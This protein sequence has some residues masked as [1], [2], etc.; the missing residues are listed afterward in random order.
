M[1]SLLLFIGVP[2]ANKNKDFTS[3]LRIDNISSI[4]MFNVVG[5]VYEKEIN[6]EKYI[7]IEE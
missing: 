3:I 7:D 6:S 2:N 1:L 4:I 5:S